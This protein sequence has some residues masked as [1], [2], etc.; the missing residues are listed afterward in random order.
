MTDIPFSILEC[1]RLRK[2]SITSSRLT[3][4]NGF[5]EG[6]GALTE[7]DLSHN[8]IDEVED[9]FMDTVRLR[10]L[11]LSYNR[12]RELPDNLHALNP[13]AD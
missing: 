10:S 5:L 11:D 3:Y 2:L 4:M 1:K 6:L 8:H 13:I 12:L 7:A 9:D